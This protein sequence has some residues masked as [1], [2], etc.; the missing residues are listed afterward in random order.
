MDLDIALKVFEVSNIDGLDLESLKIAYKNLA[1]IKHPDRNG[2][3]SKDFVKLKEA[4]VTLQKE[5]VKS[6]STGRKLKTLSKDELLDVYYNDTGK[7]RLQINLLQ[8]QT[9]DTLQETRIEVERIINEFEEK[10][11]AAQEEVKQNIEKSRQEFNKSLLNKFLFFWPN[12]RESDFW[13]KYDEELAKHSKRQTELDMEFYQIILDIY[14]RSL[15]EISQIINNN[16]T[17]E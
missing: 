8:E 10:R 5:V 17:R 14:G 12:S 7:L 6:N 2:G 16:D 11:K 4:Y 1:K 3:N 9:E 13:K 15:N